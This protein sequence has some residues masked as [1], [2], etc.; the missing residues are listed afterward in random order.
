MKLTNKELQ[1]L[2][3]E[4]ILPTGQFSFS[5]LGRSGG[6]EDLPASEYQEKALEAL[7]Y[8]KSYD[9]IIQDAAI[10]QDIDYDLLL[11]ILID[12]YIRMYPRAIFDIFG[13]MGI[14]D[15]SVGI[16]QMRSATAKS[17]SHLYVPDGYTKDQIDNMS[18]GE[19]QRMIADTPEIAINYAAAYLKHI[20]NTWQLNEKNKF[21]NLAN[22]NAVIAQLYS[23]N[24]KPRLPDPEIGYTEDNPMPK[25]AMR[26]SRAAS[27]A[28]ALRGDIQLSDIQLSENIILNV[29]DIKKLIKILLI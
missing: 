12:E 13:Y 2:I 14:I 22:K 17:V 6:P 10:D 25:A 9:Y 1:Q 11:G 20:E 18:I 3:R 7:N 29:K 19:L 26:G 5:A 8:L 15:T 23:L 4:S 27:I 24:K 16:S 21:F 28:A